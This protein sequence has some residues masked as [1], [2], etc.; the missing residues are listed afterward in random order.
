MR[1]LKN[2]GFPPFFCALRHFPAFGDKPP[3]NI[4]LIRIARHQRGCIDPFMQ[5]Y[6]DLI[7]NITRVMM[8]RGITQDDLVPSVAPANI[9]DKT[10]RR[11]RYLDGW[12]L[13]KLADALGVTVEEL[14]AQN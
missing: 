9:L 7:E 12:M 8:D 14:K 5:N 4:A 6:P 1:R 3:V 10:L 11:Q 13:A 2:P